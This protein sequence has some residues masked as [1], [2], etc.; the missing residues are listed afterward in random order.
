MAVLLTATVVSA[1]TAPVRAQDPA[2]PPGADVRWLPCER[3]AMMHWVPFDER[4]LFAM[5]KITREQA[6]AWIDDDVHH[7][8]AQ[9]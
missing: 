1:V 9:L 6:N 5:L 8:F 2:A 3:W 7:T 4:R